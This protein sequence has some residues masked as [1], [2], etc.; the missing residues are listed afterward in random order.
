MTQEI[1]VHLEKAPGLENYA[2]ALCR[3][4]ATLFY[5]AVCDSV[6]VMCNGK[7]NVVLLMLYLVFHV[8]L[9]NVNHCKICT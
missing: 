4:H 9:R 3:E 6:S 7:K 8:Y 1:S 2:T 5:T